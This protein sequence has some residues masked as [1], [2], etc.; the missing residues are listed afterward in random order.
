MLKLP[1][2]ITVSFGGALE[3]ISIDT[4]NISEKAFPVELYMAPAVGIETTIKWV[5]Y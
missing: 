1:K 5:R 3:E 2:L 4:L